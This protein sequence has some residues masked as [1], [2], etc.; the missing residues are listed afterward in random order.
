M[1][2]K[3]KLVQEIILAG[4]SKGDGLYWSEGARFFEENQEQKR[5]GGN[6]KFC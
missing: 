4:G 5:E 2:K 6:K 3:K 1:F